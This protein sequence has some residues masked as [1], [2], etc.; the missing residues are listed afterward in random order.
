MRLFVFLVYVQNI[1]ASSVFNVL[2]PKQ[3]I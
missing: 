1:E 2:V 3:E